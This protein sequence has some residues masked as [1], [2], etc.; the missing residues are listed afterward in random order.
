MKGVS[1]SK[2]KCMYDSY[3]DKIAQGT[4]TEP[5]L[6][7]WFEIFTPIE[8]TVWQGIRNSGMLFFPQFPVF[9]FFLDF[10]NPYLKIA[11]E[12]DGAKFHKKERDI[13]RDEKLWEAGWR[14]FRIKG[15]ECFNQAPLPDWYYDGEGWVCEE[16]LKC[17]YIESC[18][19]VIASIRGVYFNDASYMIR[20]L[21]HRLKS[22]RKHT[23][24]Q[25]PELQT[26]S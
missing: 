9:N 2:I 13:K 21:E 16:F 3:S 19:G 4:L 25:Y 17:H 22:L 6:M 24:I 11:I 1:Y 12:A 7:D 15:K 8:K 5:Y 20:D 10:G 14:V 23:Y 18:D 26:K